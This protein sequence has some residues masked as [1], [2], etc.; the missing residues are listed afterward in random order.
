MG[1][2]A[3]ERFDVD[4]RLG[5]LPGELAELARFVLLQSLDEHVP[6]LQDSDAGPFQRLASGAS[7]LEEEV[8]DPAALD[9][10]GATALDAHA[11]T[12]EGFAHLGQ[13]SGSIL[14]RDRQIFHAPIV[15]P[16]SQRHLKGMQ[17]PFH[18]GELEMQRR[19]GVRDEAQA[20][21]RIIARR[22]PPA[23]GRFLAHQRIAV[24]ASLD[25]EGRVWASLL[26]GRPGFIAAVDQTLL[27]LEAQPAPDDPLLANL[28]ARPE[29]GLLV[30]D[31][32]T[33]QRMRFNG[34]GLVSPEGL[35]L[36]VDQVY[37]NC[38]KYIQLRRLESELGAPPGAARASD[39]LGARQQSFIANADTFFIGS[40]HPQ[41][42][43]D[44]SH[45]G[46]FPGFVRV[47]GPDRLSF[48][49]YPGSGM[50]NTLG[51]LV[52]NPRA[53]LLFV[54]FA[55]GD[56]LQLTGRAQ[57]DPQFTVVFEIE[58]VLETPRGNS[59]RSQLIEYSPAN[60]ELSHPGAA[61]I[62]RDEGRRGAGE[63]E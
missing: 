52:A 19:A 16:P 15:T 2:V 3:V 9:D 13:R 38:P 6:L 23:A 7:I 11:G 14:E 26:S 63:G 36:L 5:H 39:R 59:L 12:P 22:I 46:G 44:A 31:P 42:G 58:A 29:L 54:D 21:G 4:A 37:G 60:P 48:P 57:I 1:V 17:G 34:R 49:D 43:A 50:F 30:L 56:V 45:R 25:A 32:Q 40:V 35:F 18:A 27:R 24:A 51:N 41:G 62:V 53:G 10:P 8:R 55:T 28:A 33:R 20:V 61:G 47:L